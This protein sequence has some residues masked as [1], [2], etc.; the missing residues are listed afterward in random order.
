MSSGI[1]KNV[2]R[3]IAIAG[4]SGFV[5]KSLVKRISELSDVSLVRGLSRSQ[6]EVQSD[7]VQF[8]TCDLF[9]LKDVDLGLQG[10]D[11]AIYLVHSMLPSAELAQGNFEDYDLILAD[12]FARAC[13]KNNVRRVTYLSGIIPPH[14]ES[15]PETLSKHLRSR[16]E[17]EKVFQAYGLRL[18]SLRASIIMGQGGSSFEMILRL[19]DRLPAMICPSWTQ[20]R[21]NPVHVD[22][23]CETFAHVLEHQDLEGIYDLSGPETLS[24]F[25]MIQKCSEFFH[26]NRLLFN[27]PMFSPKLSRL[28]VSAVTGAPSNLV[29]PLIESLKHEMLADPEKILKIPNWKYKSFEQALSEIGSLHS[30]QSH[31]PKAYTVTAPLEKLNVVQSVQR[32]S[33]PSHLDAEGA[34]Q[35]YVKFLN[36]Y[37]KGLIAVETVGVESTFYVRATHSA[38]LVLEYSLERSTPDRVLFY[39]KGGLLDRGRDRSRLEFRRCRHEDSLIVAIHDYRPRLAWYVY[40]YTQAIFHLKVMREFSTYLSA[41]R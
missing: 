32:I 15:N 33:V 26:R 2:S 8:L 27:I 16:L 35:A 29:Y 38:L 20:G 14:G 28:W 41:L 13:V 36:S 31:T 1:K 34:A 22:D 18:V 7:R 3:K 11:E 39:I 40:K 6:S 9:S 19:V 12:N 30:E 10:I 4:A 21:S 24:Y 17:V 25:E 23:V 5:G 37:F